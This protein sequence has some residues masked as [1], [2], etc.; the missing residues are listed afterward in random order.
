MRQK[1]LYVSVVF[2][3][4]V[5]IFAGCAEERIHVE[6]TA[7]RM[8]DQEQDCP[9]AFFYFNISNPGPQVMKDLSME[10]IFFKIN[11]FEL[12]NQLMN[13][14]FQVNWSSLSPGNTDTARF[15]TFLNPLVTPE[16]ALE[17]WN[18]TVH[19]QMTFKISW[20]EK[21]TYTTTQTFDWYFSLEQ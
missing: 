13:S 21:R 17:L 9:H 7:M 12:S 11:E 8:Y 15:E 4:I 2:L 5:S 18:K 1:A 14:T 16:T 19:W 10:V 20:R 6:A 3:F